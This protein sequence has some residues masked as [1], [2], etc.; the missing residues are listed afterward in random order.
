MPGR[1]CLERPDPGCSWRCGTIGLADRAFERARRP[2]H[3]LHIV[4]F[5]GLHPRTSGL[6][7]S[8]GLDRGAFRTE[9]ALTLGLPL[10]T[11]LVLAEQFP[12]TGVRIRK[13]LHTLSLLGLGGFIIG[14]FVTNGSSLAAAG[15]FIFPVLVVPDAMALALGYFGARAAGL[16][17][18]ILLGQFKG[19]GGASSRRDGGSGI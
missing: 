11:G 3:S 6:L 9:T 2:D 10:A 18:V 12:R 14:A 7:R 8:I 13:P 15:S 5:A 16:G 1:K 17:L 4:L 19:L